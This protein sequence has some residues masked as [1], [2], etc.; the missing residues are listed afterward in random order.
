MWE[1]ILQIDED[2]GN[3]EKTAEGTDE[4]KR[5]GKT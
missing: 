4:T 1:W 5:G 2:K 3:A